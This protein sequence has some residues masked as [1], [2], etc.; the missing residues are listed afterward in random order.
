MS[1]FTP[2]QERQISDAIS[3]MEQKTSGEILAV[4]AARSDS[5]LYVPF[6]WAALIALLVPWPMIYFTWA[7][8]TWIYLVQL[9]VFFVLLALFLPQPIRLSLVPASVKRL[10]AHRRAV[11]QFLAQNLHTTEGR[12][13]VLIFVS[14]AEHYAEI[15]ADSGIHDRVP[16]GTWQEIVDRLTHDIGKGDPAQAFV[17]AINAAGEHLTRHFPPGPHDPNELPDHLIVLD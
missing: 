12:T 10:H 2:E 11:E 1:L 5:Y 17:N 6:L 16:P 3:A 7:P 13:G 8:V 4:I 9:I 14:V 15:I